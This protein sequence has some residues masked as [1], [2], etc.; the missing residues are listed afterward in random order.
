MGVL[1]S[2]KE[3]NKQLTLHLLLAGPRGSLWNQLL[4]SV[5]TSEFPQH[6]GSVNWNLTLVNGIGKLWFQ[7]R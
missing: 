6:M 2:G 3:Q 7:F 5:L 1:H 4:Y